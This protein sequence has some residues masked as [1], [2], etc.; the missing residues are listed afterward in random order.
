M[1]PSSIAGGL[2]RRETVAKHRSCFVAGPKNRQPNAGSTFVEA[3]DASTA[4]LVEAAVDNV[5]V[6]R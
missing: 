6:S 4:S 1:S 2:W 5:V 3:A